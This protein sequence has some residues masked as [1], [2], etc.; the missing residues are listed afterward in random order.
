[1]MKK[2]NA[3]VGVEQLE[4]LPPRPCVVS[5]SP[6][7]V[8]PDDAGA[9]IATSLQKAVLPAIQCSRLDALDAPRVSVLEFAH[10][11]SS[12][13]RNLIAEPALAECIEPRQLHD[14]PLVF[15]RQR[16]DEVCAAIDDL[17]LRSRHVVV[18]ENCLWAVCYAIG[19]AKRECRRENIDVPTCIRRTSLHLPRIAFTGGATVRPGTVALA[20]PASL[21]PS[22]APA[23]EDDGVVLL[24]FLRNP[25]ELYEALGSGPSLRACRDALAVEGHPCKLITGTH[26]FVHPW[27]YRRVIQTLNGLNLFP[28]HVVTVWSLEHLVAESVADIRPR[29]LVKKRETL[30]DGSG[31][32]EGASGFVLALPPSLTTGGPA[33]GD[34]QVARALQDK[35]YEEYAN[36]PLRETLYDSEYEGAVK[37]SL[38][39]YFF[40]VVK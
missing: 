11:T 9:G 32:E 12:F 10:A 33:T 14:E 27:Q 34:D 5:Q 19:R 7:V 20:S 21:E 22:A 36:E 17:G 35:E 4:R 1:M 2:V 26:I 30:A 23:Q 6:S 18:E 13:Q 28:S 3:Q 37:W 39:E 25:R 24:S 16:N 8:A 15:V 31:I 38:R 29:I 40:N